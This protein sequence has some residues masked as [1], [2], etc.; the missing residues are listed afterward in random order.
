MANKT[1]N[2]LNSRFGI[3]NADEVEVQKKRGVK[4]VPKRPPLQQFTG[5]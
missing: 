3:T 1:I 5:G 4:Q 2:Q